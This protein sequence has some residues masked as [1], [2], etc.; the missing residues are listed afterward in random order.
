MTHAKEIPKYELDLV[1]TKFYCIQ[2]IVEKKWEYNETIHQLF[3]NLKEAY[4]S[5]RKEALYNILIESVIRMKIVNWLK[6]V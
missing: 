5:V 1:G 2:Q 4:D 3:I 6:C